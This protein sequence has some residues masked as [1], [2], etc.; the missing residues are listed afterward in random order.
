[1][2][3]DEQTERV[4]NFKVFTSAEYLR[5]ARCVGKEIDG[6]AMSKMFRKLVTV[7]PTWKSLK[8]PTGVKQCAFY[9]IIFFRSLVREIF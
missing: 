7:S 8:H 9:L 6:K 1:M 2:F 5:W 3:C 4:S